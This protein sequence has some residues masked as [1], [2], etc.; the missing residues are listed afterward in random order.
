M[1]LMSDG[2]GEQSQGSRRLLGEGWVLGQVSPINSPWG[3]PQKAGSL[4]KLL[5][6]SRFWHRGTSVLTAS[7]LKAKFH[8]EAQVSGQDC[9]LIIRAHTYESSSAKCFIC[10]SPLTFQQGTIVLTLFYRLRH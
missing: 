1:C 2:E 7:F 6:K 5:E 9:T 3:G 10:T 4:E 8:A